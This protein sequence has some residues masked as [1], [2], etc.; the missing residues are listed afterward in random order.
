MLANVSI[1]DYQVTF[2]A[3]MRSQ[4]TAI[5]IRAKNKK[6]IRSREGTSTT[7]TVSKSTFDFG[8]F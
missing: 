4:S 8:D 3:S 2:D 5:P 7:L 1:I 6:L